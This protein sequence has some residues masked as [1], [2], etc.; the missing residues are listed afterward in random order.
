[1]KLPDFN[2]TFVLT[3]D[4]SLVAV[5]AVLEQDFG[6]GLQP[7]AYE[8]KKLSSSESRLSAY[9]RELLGIIWS[10]GKWRQYL[11]GQRFIIQTD[12]S[13]LRHLP[14]QPSVNRRIWKW[15][16]ILQTY[17]CEIRHIPG[18]RNP[19]DAL[20][21]R[22]WVRD[23]QRIKGTKLKDEEFVKI[24]RVKKDASDSDIQ[25]ALDALFAEPMQMEKGL[26]NV[27]EGQNCEEPT[28]SLCVS[29]STVTLQTNLLD[30]IWQILHNDFQ[31]GHIV[32]EMEERNLTLWEKDEIK[33]KMTKNELF[34]HDSRRS[35][36]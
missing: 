7:I 1:M 20:T 36:F 17:D 6:H 28:A 29:K 23:K 26:I 8:S 9:E 4:A 19:A 13:S 31:Y 12:H 11:T 14:N 22:S 16:G 15:M 5:G 27:L 10:L 18:S 32:K 33:F 24:L 35:K 25:D 3:T 30:K 2:K 34:I 21:R